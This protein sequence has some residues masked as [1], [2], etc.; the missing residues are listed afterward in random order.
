VFQLLDNKDPE[1]ARCAFISFNSKI[2]GTKC[3][4]LFLADLEGYF[5]KYSI[6]LS[7]SSFLA[8]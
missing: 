5:L 8:S 6:I 3:N 1:G 7:I 2:L 4:L